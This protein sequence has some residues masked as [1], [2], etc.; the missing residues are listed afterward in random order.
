[1]K[2]KNKK[3][4]KMAYAS[5]PSFEVEVVLPGRLAFSYAHFVRTTNKNF[6]KR[7]FYWLDYLAEQFKL[8]TRGLQLLCFIFF[9]MFFFLTKIRF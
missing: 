3:R 7:Y 8:Q 5:F 4:K 1:M 2:A 9:I 6:K